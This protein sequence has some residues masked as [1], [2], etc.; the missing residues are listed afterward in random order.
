MSSHRNN[1]GFTLLE[2][3]VA[4]TATMLVV[5]TVY[6]VG[7]A[8]QRHFHEQQRIAQTQMS[9]RMAMEQLRRD[10]S[11]AGFLGSPNTMLEQRCLPPLAEMQAVAFEN[12]VGTIAN[13]GENGSQADRLVLTG[14]YATGDMY[15]VRGLDATGSRLFLQTDW[16]G[17]RRSLMDSTG[18]TVD[19]ARFESVFLPGRKVMIRT[20]DNYTFYLTINS[21]DAATASITINPG[22]AG[23]SCGGSFAGSAIAPISQ[24][25]YTVTPFSSTAA[26]ASL[27]AINAASNMTGDVGSVLLRREL[28][29]DTGVPIVGSERAVLEFAVDFNIDFIVDQNITRG[30]PPNLVRVDGS[31]GPA[32]AIA[33]PG[34]AAANPGPQNLRSLIVRLA[35]RT[36]EQDPRFPFVAPVPGE[37]MTRFRT[38]P[39]LAGAARVRTLQT[40]ILVP[41]V[42]YPGLK[43]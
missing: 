16:Q 25:E 2:L 20:Q 11:M 27:A 26:G 8:S 38:N 32:A 41:N 30:L 14:N 35:A 28:V 4:L 13:G 6:Y 39:A 36:A 10:V 12:N 18:T 22:L 43:Q 42:A 23:V 15:L 7:G 1:E 5:S 21:R 3:L 17:F 37:A 29:A 19:T 31:T 33:G 9:V 40:E 34:T 24:I